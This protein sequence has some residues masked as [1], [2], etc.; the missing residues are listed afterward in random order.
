MISFRMH[1]KPF[2]SLVFKHKSCNY[3]TAVVEAGEVY[4]NKSKRDECQNNQ[5]MSVTHKPTLSWLALLRLWW[6]QPDR[7]PFIIL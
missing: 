2:I 3:M 5:L 1:G 6:R 4:G 7:A